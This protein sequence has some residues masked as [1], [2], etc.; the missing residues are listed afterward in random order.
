[1]HGIKGTVIVR[2]LIISSGVNAE[3]DAVISDDD[4][5]DL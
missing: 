5:E 4:G 1:M 2:L 3:H